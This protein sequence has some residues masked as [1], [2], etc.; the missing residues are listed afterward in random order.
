MVATELIAPEL[1]ELLSAVRAAV[2]RALVA[3]YGTEVGREAAADAL[4]WS[5]EHHHMLAAMANPNGYLYRVGQSAARRHLRLQQ[6]PTAT[7]PRPIISEESADLDLRRA[8]MELPQRQR[9]AVFLVHCAGY[10]YR[11][12]ADVLDTTTGNIGSLISRGLTHL[13]GLLEQ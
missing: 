4:A 12:A 10:S 9:A 8:L 1:D 3:R 13:R 6:Q 11:A 5:V 2:E 7:V